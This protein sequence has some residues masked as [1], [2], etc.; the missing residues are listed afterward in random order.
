KQ[1]K[2]IMERGELVPDQLVCDMVAQRLREKDC[3]TGFILDGFPRTVGQAEWLDGLLE[4]DFFPASR[5]SRRAPVVINVAVGYNQLMQRLTGR[6][7]CPTC[8]RIYNVHFQPPRVADTC[9]VDG[10]KLV[11][12][13][14]DREDV[15]AERLK[16]YERQT[17]PL[18]DYYRAKGRLREVNGNQD[19]AKVTAEVLKVLGNADFL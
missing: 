12:R 7:S 13:K 3:D 5:P 11:T 14:D 16:A 17:L 1:A 18:A 9:D 4:G 8:G 6:R 15:I 10:A 2:A 19:S